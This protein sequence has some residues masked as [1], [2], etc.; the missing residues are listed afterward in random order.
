[1]GMKVLGRHVAVNTYWCTRR[2]HGDGD[3]KFSVR[4]RVAG[5][6]YKGNP[7]VET[8]LKMGKEYHFDITKVSEEKFHKEYIYLPGV[9][10]YDTPCYEWVKDPTKEDFIEYIKR[11]SDFPICRIPSDCREGRCEVEWKDDIFLFGLRPP[12][13]YPSRSIGTAEF[14]N[15]VWYF[16]TLGLVSS[17]EMRREVG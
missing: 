6:D 13:E 8:R 14:R 2:I 11:Y 4:A 12:L 3:A 9:D 15:A 10:D 1:M 16:T 7:L 17:V 5:L